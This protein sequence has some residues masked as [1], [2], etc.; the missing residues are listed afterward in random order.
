[1]FRDEETRTLLLS[2]F[3]KEMK[4]YVKSIEL[5]PLFE[6]EK[7]FYQD[8]NPTLDN[9][10]QSAQVFE[11][12]EDKV[13]PAELIYSKDII[14]HEKGQEAFDNLTEKRRQAEERRR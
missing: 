4:K 12:L 13:D 5:K 1:M 14:V 10:A 7:V 2:W 6:G 11:C 9:Q 8:N 3:H